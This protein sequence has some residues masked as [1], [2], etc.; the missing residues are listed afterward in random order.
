[1]DVD[2]RFEEALAQ[3]R[4][5]GTFLFPHGGAMQ[6]DIFKKARAAGAYP[7]TVGVHD[8]LD[9]CQM[10]AIRDT[11][12]VHLI[13]GHVTFHD[14]DI[15]RIS[16]GMI[17]GRRMARVV[18]DF[19]RR[20]VPGF[21]RAF[22][23]ATADDL[24]IRA[25]RWSD[26][27]FVFTRAMKE[28]LTRFDDAVGRGVVERDMHKHPGERAWGVQTFT[29]DTF[30]VPYRCLVPRQVEGLLMGAGRSVSAQHPYLLRVMAHTMVVG[31]AAGAAAAVAARDRS[32]P[33][34]VDVRA[35]QAELRRQGVGLGRLNRN[36]P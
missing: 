10:H 33:R 16:R 18:T 35:V 14:L 21:E 36:T 17:D 32:M 11:G 8:T 2:W 23:V 4:D 28:N 15:E 22:V 20:R 19:F 26:G 1:M 30:D 7:E 12:I 24:G 5:T 34:E 13:T 27:D 29:D 25:S 9:A 6:M 3:Y 31:Q